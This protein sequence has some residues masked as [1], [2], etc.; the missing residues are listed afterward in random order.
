M[1]AMWDRGAGEGRGQDWPI[2]QEKV[3]MWNLRGNLPVFRTLELVQTFA[4]V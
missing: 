4:E 3:E 1:V 2:F